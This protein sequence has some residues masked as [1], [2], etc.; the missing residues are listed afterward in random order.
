MRKI[1]IVLPKTS[2]WYDAQN[3]L[4]CYDLNIEQY[5]KSTDL[6]N[7]YKSRVFRISA[8]VPIADWRT[9]WNLLY[10]NQYIN[11]PE[12]LT[13]YMNNNNFMNILN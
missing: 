13:F 8:Y 2:F 7:G 6:G 9:K 1:N 4:Y 5:V 11:N 10:N 12:T 3:S